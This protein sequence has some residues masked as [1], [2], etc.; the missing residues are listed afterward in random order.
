MDD[1]ITDFSVKRINLR[2]Y[3]Y[4]QS[5]QNSGNVDAFNAELE[6][7]Y[8]GNLIDESLT[9]EISDSE[10]AKIREEIVKIDNDKINI[11]KSIKEKELE[12]SEIIRRIEYI[13]KEIEQIKLGNKLEGIN[14]FV[15]SPL[16]F[17]LNLF[18]LLMLS[19]YLFLFYVSAAYRV[20][21]TNTDEIASNMADG[22]DSITILPS[23]YELSDALHYNYL[24]LFVPFI[25]YAFGYA[26]HVAL[27]KKGYLKF[28]FASS[29]IVVTFILDFLLAY[30]IHYNTESAKEMIGLSAEVWSKSSTFYIILFMGFVVYMIWSL[31][32]D[33]LMKE[34]KKRDVL[35]KRAEIINELQLE[36]ALIEKAINSLNFDIINLENQKKVKVD[37]LDNTKIPI[38]FI[39]Q[40]ISEFYAGWIQFL[41]GFEN[42]KSRL[43]DC[44]LAHDN[45]LIKHNL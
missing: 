2:Q 6:L 44:R 27:E 7:I 35:N 17:T 16:K 28:L 34:W 42:Y 23:P 43:E 18:F 13:K 25:F 8:Q 31:L 20:F 38:L 37:S 3:G 9:L 30:K 12:K 36:I 11:D 26:L 22:L 33:S 39:K 15:F 4:E 24:L 29:L 45:F 21:Y 41:S 5:G 1:K 19:F 10:K 14:G 32:L 40:S